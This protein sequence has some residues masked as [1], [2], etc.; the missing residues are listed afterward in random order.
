MAKQLSVRV[1]GLDRSFPAELVATGAAAKQ[2]FEAAA[3]GP[4]VHLLLAGEQDYH[5]RLTID[6]PAPAALIAAARKPVTVKFAGRTTS[7]RR[8]LAG[9]SGHGPKDSHQ[10]ALDLTAGIFGAAPLW[11]LPDGT[12][13]AAADGPAPRDEDALPV[14]VAA[15][16]WVSTRRTT[17]FECLFPPSP[18]HPELPVR[19]EHLTADQA[20]ALVDQLEAI[21]AAA[22][23]VSDLDAVDAA[24]IRSAAAT[25]LS[26][27]I[28]TVLKDASFRAVADRAAAR[29]LRL[30]DDED[31]PG[32][33][34]DLRAHAINLLSMRGPALAKT[35]QTRVQA[36]L[37]GL[38]RAAPPYAE[39]K[40]TWRFTLN[41]GGEFLAG[42]I[43]IFETKFD[44]KKIDVPADAPASPNPWGGGYTVLQAPFKGPA[45][46]DILVF[47]R[48]A[49]PRD[50]NHEMSL[51]YFT[52]LL[53]S[54]HANLGA[55]DMKAALAPV[56]QDGYK[57]MF[58]CQCA[59]LTTRFAISRMFPDADIYSSWDSTYFTTGPDGETVSSEGIDCF[60]AVLHGM[61]AGEDFA[62]IDKRLRKAQWRHEQSR[63]PEF[64]Q[65][66]GP[67]HPAV[68]AKYED[69]N[70]DGKAD[71][72]DGFL[73]LR[74]VEIAEAVHD[75]ATPKPPGVA[76]SQIGGA[77]ASGL[78]WAAGSLNRATQ[79]SELWD[80][81]PGQSEG[82]YIFRAGGFYSP[83]DPPRDVSVGEG[84]AIDLGLAPAVVRYTKDGNSLSAEVLCH[85]WLSHSAQELKRLLVAAE[86]YWRAIDLGHLETKAPLD[87]PGGQRAGLLLLL[88][89][90]LEFPADPNLLDGLWESALDMLQLPRLSR[91]L[92][93]RC[94]D[95]TDH[96]NG[97][98]YGSTRGIAALLGTPKKP[99][100]V[101]AASEVAHEELVN[102]P[103]HVGRARPLRLPVIPDKPAVA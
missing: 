91:S 11:L 96:D 78:N 77:A 80:S 44:F 33:R 76:A 86:A 84:P 42:Q 60:M 17:S 36:L 28:A 25:V 55:F 14:V 32:G 34:P 58:N 83:E 19:S 15:A 40:G 24:Q 73:D 90:L 5:A 26:H 63:V 93:R 9:L 88:A 52:G 27:V 39:I 10:P 20:E 8:T 66:I 99:G 31:A 89:G 51:P 102:G 29:L 79:Y 43:K 92:V 61:A 101:K 68:V 85:A 72:Y 59:G 98:Y 65:F 70:R 4:G 56:Q 87:T 62:A 97:N 74:I 75:S 7:V 13:A 49:S 69:I 47:A 82:F 21:L 41:A 46:Q 18:F 6:G 1:R 22:T 67:A 103:A 53:I 23:P 94:I 95:D 64:V 2:S 16:R 12:L 81:L 3:A 71:F 54:R 57:L 48:T 30:V 35:D 50:E 100:A 37:R 38:R 45:G